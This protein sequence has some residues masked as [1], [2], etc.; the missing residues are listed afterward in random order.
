MSDWELW[1]L[2]TSANTQWLRIGENSVLTVDDWCYNYLYI[3]DIIKV[4]N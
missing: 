3:G 4:I 1:S 2:K